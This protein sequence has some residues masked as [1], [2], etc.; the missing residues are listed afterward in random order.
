MQL[1]LA[2]PRQQL[3]LL[4]SVASLPVPFLLFEEAPV[5]GP[6]WCLATAADKEGLGGFLEAHA[7][8]E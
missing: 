7:A 1:L 5:A 3:P 2:L 4:L 6:G 8:S